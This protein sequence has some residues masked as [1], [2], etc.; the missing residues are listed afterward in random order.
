MLDS[1]LSSQDAIENAHLLAD[2]DIVSLASIVVRWSYFDLDVEISSSTATNSFVTLTNIF[3]ID[4][5]FDTSR[6]LDEVFLSFFF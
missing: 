6:D 4:I 2:V 1:D 3:E 5:M